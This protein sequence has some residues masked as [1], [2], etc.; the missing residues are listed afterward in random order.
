MGRVLGRMQT[1]AHPALACKCRGFKYLAISHRES[2]IYTQVAESMVFR[3]KKLA[4]GTILVPLRASAHIAL[5]STL[6]PG[7]RSHA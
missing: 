5:Y 1:A 4:S 2:N 3:K 6:I 7:T